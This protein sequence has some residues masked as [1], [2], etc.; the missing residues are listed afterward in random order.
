MQQRDA[1]GSMP[2][3]TAA[4]RKRDWSDP[5]A[6]ALACVTRGASL[7]PTLAR[8]SE[9]QQRAWRYVHNQMRPARIRDRGPR[10][11]GRRGG[12]EGRGGRV[13]PLIDIVRI[14]RRII[15]REKFKGQ[16]RR[17]KR[18]SLFLTTGGP[19]RTDAK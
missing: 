14:E 11:P 13:V 6:R 12:G 15:R 16:T 2:E 10:S 3:D 9:M 4:S 8:L 1:F 5:V 18:K 17:V 19:S 7:E